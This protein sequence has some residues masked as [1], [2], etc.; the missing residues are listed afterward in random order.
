MPLNRLI[1]LTVLITFFAACKGSKVIADSNQDLK[2]AKEPQILTLIED[3]LSVLSST[4]TIDAAPPDSILT[5]TKADKKKSGLEHPVVYS[6]SDSLV[7][8][9]SSELISLYDSVAI[10]YDKIDLKAN[11]VSMSFANKRLRATGLPDSTGKPMGKP[12]F[13]ENGKGFD[14]T[15]LE[16]NFETR[17]GLIKEAITNDGDTYLHGQVAKKESNDVL[18]IK[19][20]RFTTCSDKEHPHFDIATSKAK[21]IPD[22]KVVTGPAVLRISEVPTP[23]ALPFGFFPSMEYRSSGIL[24]PEY[25]E[26]G[27]FGFF[28]RNFG[29]YFGLSDYMDLSL[30]GDLFTS[31]SFGARAE[32]RYIQKYKHNGRLALKFSQFQTG[33]PELLTDFQQSRDFSVNWSHNQDIKAHP[34][35]NFK[36]DVNVQTSGFNRLNAGSVNA[37]TQNQFNSNISIT[38]TFR[39]SPVNLAAS[40]RHFQNTST[41]AVSFSLPE[42]VLNVSRI[43]PFKRKVAIGKPRWYEQIGLTYRLQSANQLN[44]LD[45]LLFLQPIQE[46]SRVNSGM[47]HEINL[48]TNLT[49]AQY[50]FITPSIRYDERWHLWSLNRFIDNQGK[51]VSDTVRGFHAN[52]QL[53]ISVNVSTNIFSTLWLKIGRLKGIRHTMS[54]ALAFSYRPDFSDIKTGYFGTSGQLSSYSPAQIGLYGASP[55]G[56]SGMISLGI[57]NR[58]EAK[59]AAS[60]RDSSGKDARTPILEQLRLGLN[61]DLARD[62]LNLS[63]LTISARTTLFKLISLNLNAAFDPYQYSL[64]NGQAQRI[65]AFMIEQ[66]QLFRATQIALAA[67]F[68][69]RGQRKAKAQTQEEEQVLATPNFY[70]YFIDFNI[71]YSLQVNYNVSYNKPYDRST[72]THT[73][74]LAGDINLTPRWK[75]AM[76]LNYDLANGQISTSSIDIFRDMHCWEMRISVIPFGFRQSYNFTINV[77]S[78]LLQA[79]KLNRQRGWFN[80]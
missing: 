42:M 45:S 14:A 6:A 48:N 31:L 15:E 23:L 22:D 59:M 50:L 69:L 33:D 16:Y 55:A 17:R 13:S 34:T 43:T 56:Q 65:N 54:P 25:G 57:N 26:Q 76:N 36:A 79:L 19:N 10:L 62:S 28:L 77:K 32:L 80:N 58:I 78:P 5:P 70:N 46:L 67:G 4:K 35:F 40:I 7:L 52:R 66:G 37:I 44:T 63:N 39:N 49:V 30:T 71:P 3:S 20:A 75:I 53:D 9:L 60:K 29:Y 47:R 24:L 1:L 74:G 11:F 27:N 18:Y 73:I 8:D 2:P 51:V 12:V 68:N 72:L 41:G 64:V 38:K 21:V 61:Y